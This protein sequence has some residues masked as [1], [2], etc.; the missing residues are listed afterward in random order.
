V[1]IAGEGPD[2]PFL[3]RWIAANPS[4]DARL[5]GNV[6]EQRMC[7]LYAAADLFAL[8]SF[9]DPN[10]LSVIEAGWAGLPLLVS[11]RCGNAPEAV[12]DGVNG[13]L[14][15]PDDPATIVRAVRDAVARREELP[16]MGAASRDRMTAG[17]ATDRVVSRFWDALNELGE[18]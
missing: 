6:D 15:D 7:E 11:R 10:P 18:R 16:T 2:R 4:A 9:R 14:I 12:E 8:P 1:R 13:W 3:E 17:F 5:L